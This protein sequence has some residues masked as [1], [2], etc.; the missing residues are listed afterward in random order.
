[1]PLVSALVLPHGTM[2]FDGDP[3]LHF[4]D[5]TTTA[6]Q[7]VK[8]IPPELKKDCSAIFTLTNDA[9]QSVLNTRP[10]VIFLNTPHGICLS[11]SM[12]VYTNPKA[13]GNAE[14][15][16]QWD[17]YSIEV[18]LDTT[19][20]KGLIHHL[21]GDGIPVEGIT[22]FSCYDSPL[23]WGEVVPLWYLKPLLQA[24][25]KLVIT[26]NPG[27]RLKSAKGVEE[28]ARIGKSIGAYINSL[29]QRV[30]YVCSGDLAHTHSH[31]C[32]IELYLPSPKWPAN[33]PSVTALPFDVSIENWIQAVPYSDDEI[34][35]PAKTIKPSSGVWDAVT[36]KQAKQWLDRAFVLRT[37]ALSC[38]INGFCMLQGMLEAEIS[39]QTV[40]GSRTS[41]FSTTLFCRLAP[42]YYGM[43][44]ASFIK[45]DPN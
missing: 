13:T 3:S 43:M 28:I 45:Q 25:P 8:T 11:D 7:R 44:S 19:L 6:A 41:S 10:D 27:A 40:R 32:H 38:G 14:W 15:N 2:P 23:R 24:V 22:C 26:S 21:R 36:L 18:D 42:T 35:G 4:S 9:V 17:E 39:C 5:E 37:T 12:G 29:D 33:Q 1:M 16:G 31:D 20:S 34:T 30:L